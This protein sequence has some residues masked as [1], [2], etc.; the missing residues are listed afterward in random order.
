VNNI[1]IF[2]IQ[3]I[4]N[5][6]AHDFS[7]ILI[8]AIKY[9]NWYE[10]EKVY[11]YILQEDTKLPLDNNDKPYKDDLKGIIPIGSVEFV[12]K[13]LN[14]YYN[15]S[16]IKPLNIPQEL[17][18]PEYL[19]R[20]VKIIKTDVNT[21]NAGNTPIFVKDNSKIKGWTNI[22]EYNRGYPPG[23][24]IISEV[25]EIDSEWRAFVFNNRLVGLQNYSGD[26]TMFP[27]VKLIKKMISD[28]NY[29]SAYTLDI[30]INEKNGTFIIECHDFFSC[31]LYGFSDYKV[32]PLMF[33]DTWNKLIGGKK[34]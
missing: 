23:E 19:K 4:D 17:M 1:K 25:V 12:V 8:E 10:N 11:D 5:I 28:F 14:D 27:D 16:N 6:V 34:V 18:K 9:H 7:F 22:V 31:G 29:N 24:Y 33:I 3:T 2:L 26:F 13:Y 32:L 15:I 20:W 30:G 21:I